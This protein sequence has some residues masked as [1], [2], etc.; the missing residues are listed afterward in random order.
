MA[1]SSS[2]TKSDEV[3]DLER[4]TEGFKILPPSLKLRGTGRYALNDGR[5][6]DPI[7]VQNEV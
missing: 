3:K 2:R 1:P 6:Q 7:V 4:S 5:E